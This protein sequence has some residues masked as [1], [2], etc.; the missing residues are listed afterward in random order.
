MQSL[1]HQ[2]PHHY[3]RIIN[4]IVVADTGLFVRLLDESNG[5][6][7]LEQGQDSRNWRFR[8]VRRESECSS[9]LKSGY[10]HPETKSSFF[11]LTIGHPT[12]TQRSRQKNYMALG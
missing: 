11:V 8:E 2:Q 10:R 5:Q 9:C 6:E 7:L 4:T 3:Q 1:H 12:P